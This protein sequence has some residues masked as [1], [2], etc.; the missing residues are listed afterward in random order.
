MW[1]RAR[2]FSK[3]PAALCLVAFGALLGGGIVWAKGNQSQ[4]TAC[5]EPRTNYLKLGSSCGGQEL[6]WNTEGPKGPKGDPGPAG[7]RGAQGP[8]GPQGQP[9]AR[10]PAGAAGRKGPKGD[11]NVLQVRV[12]GGGSIDL[13]GLLTLEQKLLLKITIK[14]GKI[15]KK[16]D[17]LVKKVDAAA[18]YAQTRLYQN[19]IGIEQAQNVYVDAPTAIIRCRLGFYS[20]V[21]GYDPLK[22]YT[23]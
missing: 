10:G 23:P 19:C 6:T 14:L 3:A 22:K 16:L 17:S 11:P 7:A 12:T 1:T 8:A 20:G 9:G 13:S 21:T 4:I 15:D 2:I 18:K 5:V